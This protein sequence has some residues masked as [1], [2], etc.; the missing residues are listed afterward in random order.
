[1]S[2]SYG[3][4]V[5]SYSFDNPDDARYWREP[6][7]WKITARD[8]QTNNF[9]LPTG[10][11]ELI[12]VYFMS[13]INQ[14]PLYVPE[15]T[16]Y[17]RSLG[18][19]SLEADETIEFTSASVDLSAF[20]EG[21]PPCWGEM[22]T[23]VGTGDVQVTLTWHAYA[24]IDL[25]VEDPLGETVYY[26]NDIISSGGQLDRDNTCGDF[27]EGQPENIFW[28]SEAAPSGLYKVRVHYFGDCDSTG[29]V[30][31][32]VRTVVGGQVETFTGTLSAEGN[33]QEVTTF[34]IP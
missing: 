28:P 8:G 30:Q 23:S 27:I 12:D 31:W 11:Y 10:Q 7:E 17:W 6:F 21:R 4:C 34:T 14:S 26:G 24:D 9:W 18:T 16:T 3:V 20:T 19:Y 5:K 22:T 2:T 25:Y 29:P 1:M 13:E 33:E 15:Y 32:T